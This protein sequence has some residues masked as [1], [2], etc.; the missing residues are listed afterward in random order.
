MDSR[1]PSRF[2]AFCQHSQHLTKILEKGFADD[3][4]RDCRRQLNPPTEE[5]LLYWICWRLAIFP[6]FS[7][8]WITTAYIPFI[9]A[10]V[11]RLTCRTTRY[12]DWPKEDAALPALALDVQSSPIRHAVAFRSKQVLPKRCSLMHIKLQQ[13]QQQ[14]HSPSFSASRKLIDRIS[15]YLAVHL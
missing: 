14:Q 2:A 9:L 15:Y 13:Q 10:S 5:V 11:S 7:H 1:P 4:W 6:S 12:V 3:A 8:P